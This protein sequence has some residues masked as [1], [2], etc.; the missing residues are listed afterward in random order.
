MFLLSNYLLLVLKYTIN[1]GTFF[2]VV[3]YKW[4]DLENCVILIPK[5][6]NRRCGPITWEQVNYFYLV[7]GVYMIARLYQSLSGQ[8]HNLSYYVMQ[9]A[10]FAIMELVCLIQFLVYDKKMEIVQ[11]IN[12]L[13]QLCKRIEGKFKIC[14]IM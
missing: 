8:T 14:W 6:N 2:R 3:P 5:L 4:N 13:L 10:Y 9:I 12:R 11:F 7:Y 1:I